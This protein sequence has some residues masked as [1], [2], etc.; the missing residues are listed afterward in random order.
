MLM[1]KINVNGCGCDSLEIPGILAFLK[2]KLPGD[3][4]TLVKWN[5]TKFLID[6]NGNPVK[7]CA[8][9]VPLHRCLCLCTFAPLPVC[10]YPIDF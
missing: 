6:R 7:R 8:A 1:N 3:H 5:F 4:G 9:F 2:A 10:L